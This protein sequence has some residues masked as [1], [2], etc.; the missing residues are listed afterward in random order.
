MPRKGLGGHGGEAARIVTR[1]SASPSF[2]A[3]LSPSASGTA[4]DESRRKCES[5]V[6]PERAQGPWRGRTSR[7]SSQPAWAWHRRRARPSAR[8]AAR[9]VVP[10]LHP[11]WHSHAH[12]LLQGGNCKF[13]AGIVRRCSLVVS[14]HPERVQPAICSCIV[15]VWGVVEKSALYGLVTFL[16]ELRAC[17]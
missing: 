15:V 10:R 13:L 1:P 3:P 5:E 16:G 17:E 9:R 4:S 8:P 6:T 7:R 14:W 11:A 12:G 2:G